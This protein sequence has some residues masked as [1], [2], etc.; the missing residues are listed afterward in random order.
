MKSLFGAITSR[1]RFVP[2]AT[3]RAT[4][5][6]TEEVAHDA[7]GIFFGATTGALDGDIDQ[8]NILPIDPPIHL[9]HHEPPFATASSVSGTRV[10]APARRKEDL[11]D[12]L[13]FILK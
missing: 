2:T 12:I 8:G 9:H 10:S 5:S 11:K 4:P 1:A 6:T 13:T 3:L 7:V